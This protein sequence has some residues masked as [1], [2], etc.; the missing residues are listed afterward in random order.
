[1]VIHLKHMTY[2]YFRPSFSIITYIC[3]YIY[4]YIYENV[5]KC[6]YIY[7]YIYICMYNHLLME[8]NS[9]KTYDVF[10]FSTVFFNN[11]IHMYIYVYEYMYIYIHTHI[12]KVK[13]CIY[14]HLLTEGNSFKTY[15]VFLFS[16]VFF[17]NGIAYTVEM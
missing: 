2:S 3:I 6:I 17:N 16:T 15:D 5:C 13:K 11:N 8:G 9:F 1:M 14:N 10:L 12:I 4:I 7:I